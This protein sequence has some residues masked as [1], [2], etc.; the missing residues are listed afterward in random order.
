MLYEELAPKGLE[1]V[2]V[3]MDSRPE[4]ARAQI[5]RVKPTYTSLVD[6]DHRV[7]D[8]YNMTNVPQSVWID[9]DGR[10]VRPTE[11]AGFQVSRKLR[12]VRKFYMDA[13]RDWVEKGPDSD[14]ALAEHEVKAKMPVFTDDIARAHALFHLGE[15]LHRSGNTSEAQET[16]QRAVDLH[17]E[18]WNFY[19]QMKNLES[20]WKASGP[21]YLGRV[22]SRAL[23]GASYYPLPDM[24][25]I[26]EVAG[27]RRR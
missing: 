13:V 23:G 2:T 22:I 25:G 14:Y 26:E 5:E 9:E 3:A 27:K 19:R 8:L 4:L 20:P 10:L 11:V 17:P 16:I 15:A 6:R 7:A 1:I 12:A 24:P 18:S 21:A